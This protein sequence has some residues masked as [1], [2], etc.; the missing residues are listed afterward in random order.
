MK[1]R[2]YLGVPKTALGKITLSGLIVEVLTG[3]P[4]EK[5]EIVRLLDR[6]DIEVTD[7]VKEVIKKNFPHIEL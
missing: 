6:E 4:I 2:V 5:E 7:E 3:K 1:D